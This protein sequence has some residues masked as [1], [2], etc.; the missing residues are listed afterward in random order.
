MN[1]FRKLGVID[2]DSRIQVLKSLLHVVL[3]DK[4]SK[5]NFEE[6]LLSFAE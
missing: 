6:L 3:L 4:L 5:Y 2:F 1:R